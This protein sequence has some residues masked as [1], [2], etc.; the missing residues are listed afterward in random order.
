MFYLVIQPSVHG[1][2]EVAAAMKVDGAHN[3]PTVEVMASVW[4]AAVVL[5]TVTIKVISSVIRDDGREAMQIGHYLG[6]EHVD[7]NISGG[8]MTQNEEEK[9]KKVDQVDG[10]VGEE[11][12][13]PEQPAAV[14]NRLHKRKI[15]RKLGHDFC[16]NPLAF[17]PSPSRDVHEGC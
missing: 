8:V 6:N 7:E 9:A 16:L 13:R 5:F 10:D 15:D 14:T 3:L 17:S 1:I 2:I 4:V 12:L 11:A